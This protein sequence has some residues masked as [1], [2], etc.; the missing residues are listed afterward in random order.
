M[1]N[2]PGGFYEHEF[3]PSSSSSSSLSSRRYALITAVTRNLAAFTS[4]RCAKKKVV[5]LSFGRSWCE[6]RLRL[7]IFN[8]HFRSSG[9]TAFFRSDRPHAKHIP[10]VCDYSTMTIAPGLIFSGW[11]GKNVVHPTKRKKGACVEMLSLF[12]TIL[13]SS[14]NILN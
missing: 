6:L 1:R 10:S 14:S 5:R 11:W 2:K 13:K 9:V 7:T 4:V 12:P 3:V 8:N